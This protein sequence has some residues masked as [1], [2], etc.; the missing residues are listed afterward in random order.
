MWKFRTS[1]Y[2]NK[3]YKCTI[4]RRIEST[5]GR[6]GNKAKGKAIKTRRMYKNEFQHKNANK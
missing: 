1:T 3:K 6:F 2:C 4:K 5:E